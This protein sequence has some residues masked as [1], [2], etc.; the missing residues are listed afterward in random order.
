MTP[1]TT[2][3]AG[4]LGDWL[5][6][7]ARAAKDTHRR[8]HSDGLHAEDWADCL[9]DPCHELGAL[10]GDMALGDHKRGDLT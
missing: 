6:R 3:P 5:A 8:Y 4:E 7:I 10:L 2:I 9:A 1:L